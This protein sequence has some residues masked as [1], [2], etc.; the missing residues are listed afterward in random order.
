M[1][2]R[3]DYGKAQA[4][5]RGKLTHAAVGY[6]IGLPQALCG[7]CTHFVKGAPPSCR[8]VVGPIQAKMWCRKFART[9]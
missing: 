8:L 6:K 5:P 9:Y 1:S 7:I 4:A 3:R 2:S